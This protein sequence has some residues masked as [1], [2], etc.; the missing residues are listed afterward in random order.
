MSRL[1]TPTLPPPEQCFHV[2]LAVN[3]AVQ[4]AIAQRAVRNGDTIQAEVFKAV[5][6]H[7]PDIEAAPPSL[8]VNERGP[9]HPDARPP[10]KTTVSCRFPRDM[11][12]RLEQQGRRVRH[13][14]PE[15]GEAM[16]CF[17][18]GSASHVIR[19]CIRREFAQYV[20]DQERPQAPRPPRPK[21][22]TVTFLLPLTP[23]IHTWLQRQSR[24][25]LSAQVR[26]AISTHLPVLTTSGKPLK[27]AMSFKREA[28]KASPIRIPVEMHQALQ[29]AAV[30]L[31][32]TM[33]TLARTCVAAFIRDS[34]KAQPKEAA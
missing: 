32:T 11:H 26:L 14:H 30:Q 18:R 20:Q 5:R 27:P 16:P 10:K 13:P 28:M 8:W 19:E 4:K 9:R 1:A 12:A 22:D 23:N 17:G 2:M 31:N 33:T 6:R 24:A 29:A 15:L 34:I 3:A 7:L 21:V 25:T